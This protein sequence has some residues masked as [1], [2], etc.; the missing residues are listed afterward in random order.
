MASDITYIATQE[1]WLYLA[2]VL[3]FY[4]RKVVGWAMDTYLRS[5]LVERAFTMARQQRLPDPHLLFHSD[6]GSQYTAVAFQNTLTLAKMQ[7]R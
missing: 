3:D 1:G 7:V 2:V 6:R 4:A 5:T